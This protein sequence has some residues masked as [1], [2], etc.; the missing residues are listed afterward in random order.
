M[1]DFPEF[2]RIVYGAIALVMIAIAGAVLLAATL[3]K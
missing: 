1:N 3:I 2:S